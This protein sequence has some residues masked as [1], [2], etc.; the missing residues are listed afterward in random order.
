VIGA[1]ASGIT[2][3]KTCLDH[4]LEPVVY[5]KSDHIGGNWAYRD[6]TGHASVYRSTY[7][8]TSKQLMAY[9]DYD[10]PAEFPDY[11]HHTHI[12]R[13]FEEYVDHFGVRERIRFETTVE[14]IRPD[15]DAWIVRTDDGAE[16][17]S[18][19][20]MVANGHH[21]DPN[22]PDFPGTFDGTIL[23][24]HAYKVPDG[25]EGKRVLIVGLGNSGVDISTELSR[26]A[27]DVCVAMR[28]GIRIVPKYIRG[29]PLDHVGLHPSGLLFPRKLSWAL[30]N[31]MVERIHGDV[32]RFGLPKP[33]QGLFN[34]HPTVSSE[35]LVRVGHGAIRVKPNIE[36]LDGDGVV[37][38]DGSRERFDTIIYATGYKVSFPFIPKEV[39]EVRGNRV[40]LYRY[41]VHPERPGLF[42]IGLVQPW[43]AI[44][45]ISEMQAK[46]ICRVLTD[47][48]ELPSVDDMRAD[49]ARVEAE[50]RARYVDTPRHTIQVDHYDYMR[51]LW[52]EMVP[53]G[54]LGRL[55]RPLRIVD[56]FTRVV[57][58][59]QREAQKAGGGG[60]IARVAGSS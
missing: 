52:R 23:H 60:Q 25:Y 19:A 37:F 29:M 43:G 47:K 27:D 7:I 13:Y 14:E 51:A 34:T 26:V 30:T 28:R 48:S 21:W 20:V 2:A 10:M 59:R 17:R 55:L 6:E 50:Q 35:F 33:T 57:W 8:N 44:M 36:R 32:T 40:P 58:R 15:G 9:S 16:E 49:I 41:V 42:F 54:W 38:T 3:A 5:E 45:P 31:L 46:W 1:G 53:K 22:W 24:S 56:P 39:F 18:G 4:G 11:P 12:V